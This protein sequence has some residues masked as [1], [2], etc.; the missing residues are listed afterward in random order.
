MIITLASVALSVGVTV[1]IMFALFGGVNAIAMTLT[2]VVPAVCAPVFTYV[3]LRLV[4]QLDA[5]RE[6]LRRLSITDELSGAF[7]RR[8]FLEHATQELARARRYD[9]PL[10]VAL[11]DLDDFKELNDR[12]GHAAGDAV[13]RAVSDAARATVRVNDVFARFGGEEF[14][15]LL[16]NTDEHGAHEIAERL[17]ERIAALSVQVGTEVTHLTASFGVA[18]LSP[19][20]TRVDDVL[21]R[22]DRAL[23]AAKAAGKNL[24]RIGTPVRGVSVT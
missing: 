23:Y 11:V 6:E 24:T 9:T 5:A 3:Q 18:A 21:L 4:Q 16:P 1:V 2:T 19:E 17:R 14:V 8:Y 15:V 20:D 22:A 12:F 13:L 7:N 10:S